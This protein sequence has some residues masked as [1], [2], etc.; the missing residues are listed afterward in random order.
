MKITYTNQAKQLRLTPADIKLGEPFVFVD[1]GGTP[2]DNLL[3][4]KISNTY[5]SYDGYTARFSS[6]GNTIMRR[7]TNLTGYIE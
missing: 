4:V 1:S 7:V 5:Y 2:L 3:R 6:I